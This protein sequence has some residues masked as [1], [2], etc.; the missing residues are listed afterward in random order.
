MDFL[1]KVCTCLPNKSRFMSGDP[2]PGASA[3]SRLAMGVTGCF[4]PCMMLGHYSRQ[5]SRE[6]LSQAGENKD[7]RVGTWVTLRMMRNLRRVELGVGERE[8]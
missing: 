2:I 8:R 4:I 7:L 5:C 3:I 6:L 1:Q